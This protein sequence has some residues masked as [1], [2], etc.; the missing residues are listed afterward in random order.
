MSRRRTALFALQPGVTDRSRRAHGFSGVGS[1]QRWILR[2]AR[3]AGLPYPERGRTSCAGEEDRM[4]MELAS[5][6]RGVAVA[7]LLALGAGCGDETSPAG[8]A[9]GS[10]TGSGSGG[11]D[12]SGSGSGADASSSGSGGSAGSGGGATELGCEAGDESGLVEV[13]PEYFDGPPAEFPAGGDIVPGAYELA[14]I[15]VYVELGAEPVEV[16]PMTALWELTDDQARQSLSTTD[17]QGD[18]IFGY[19]LSSYTTEGAFITLTITCTHSDSEPGEPS[20]LEY[21]AT[22]DAFVTFVNLPGEAI[23]ARRYTRR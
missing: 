17:G 7:A 5:W 21:T 11:D 6:S 23:I 14:A 16:G 15:E 9:S 2:Q 13:F 1:E 19:I 8:T 12:G 10:G 18:P 4:R 22:G 3:A 20:A